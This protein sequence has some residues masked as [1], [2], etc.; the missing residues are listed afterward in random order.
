M[1]T[2]QNKYAMRSVP[3]PL[4]LLGAGTLTIDVEPKECAQLN[5]THNS[6]YHRVARP[7][8]LL[9]NISSAADGSCLV[10]ENSVPPRTRSW[11]SSSLVF[12]AVIL[13]VVLLKDD[14]NN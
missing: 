7:S 9:C 8:L 12:V 1:L 2:V 10:H 6:L 13:V 4:F 11:C 3:D 14:T 5:S